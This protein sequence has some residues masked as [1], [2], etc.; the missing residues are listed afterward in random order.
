MVSIVADTVYCSE[1]NIVL[2]CTNFRLKGTEQSDGKMDGLH[3]LHL[4]LVAAGHNKFV[5]NR[6]KADC[7]EIVFQFA[8]LYNKAERLR[9]RRQ[10]ATA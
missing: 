4:I 2:K 10:R 1:T 3:H 6:T 8:Q 7:V 9:I 5:M